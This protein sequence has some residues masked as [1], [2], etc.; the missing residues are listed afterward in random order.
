M[1]FLTQM[2]K[3]LSKPRNTLGRRIK[4]HIFIGIAL[5]AVVMGIG[6]LPLLFVYFWGP[7]KD[8][9]GSTGQEPANSKF[10][11]EE[12]TFQNG[13]VTLSGTLVR[14]LA[15]GPHPVIVILG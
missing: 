1:F 7:S 14:P 5:F 6:L 9:A 11:E 12:V 2:D 3:P 4:R 15:K 8:G 10:I 13:D